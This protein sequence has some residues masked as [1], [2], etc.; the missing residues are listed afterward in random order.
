VVTI[1]PFH[2]MPSVVWLHRGYQPFIRV[3][4]IYIHV[5]VA[6]LVPMCSNID[7]TMVVYCSLDRWR[8]DEECESSTDGKTE[9]ADGEDDGPQSAAS[10]G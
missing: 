9:S 2:I 3:A 7:V 4:L 10:D 1:S 6:N 8:H 5:H